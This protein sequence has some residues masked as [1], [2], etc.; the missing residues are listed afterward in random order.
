[1]LV[2][3]TTGAGAAAAEAAG[4]GEELDGAKEEGE[5]EDADCGARRLLALALL[6]PPVGSEVTG[7]GMAKGRAHSSMLLNVGEVGN[8]DER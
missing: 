7:S 5:A 3:S 4:A 6:G 2:R 8:D 1:M